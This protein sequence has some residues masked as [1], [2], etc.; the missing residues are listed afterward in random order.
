[1]ADVRKSRTD[2]LIE[3]LRRPGAAYSRF[4]IPLDPQ[5]GLI[6][7]FSVVLVQQLG[8]P[9]PATPV[10][11][12]AGARAAADPLHGAYALGLA[13][14]ASAIGSLP[15]FWA[16]RRYGYRVLRLV[17]RISLSPDAC[18]RRTETLFERYG[19]A[20]LVVAKFVP[21]LARVGPPLA[22]TFRYGAGGF[23]FFYGLGNA[24]WAGAGL[25]AGVVFQ[26]EIDWFIG[27]LALFGGHAVLVVLGLLALY[28]AYRWLVRRRFLASLRTS[29]I[30]VAELKK[31]MERGEMPIV[32]DVRS[33]THRKLD[34]R[35]IP[36]ARAIDLEDLDGPL[37]Q[38]PG[39]RD[40]VVYCA[41]PN[42][43][44]AVRVATLL[45]RH[46]ISQVRSLAGGFDAWF[47]A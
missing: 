16:G 27:A 30:E 3:K 33:S 47:K 6:A 38:I 39:G 10:L 40:V 32:L 9:I 13:I 22:G 1:M 23:L 24:L 35:M 5:A 21:G 7:V 2:E 43:A 15:W 34:P 17:C 14:L 26:A 8:A 46:G 31:R 18:V 45:R 36:G 25:V 42:D 19:A 12:L 20:S 41:C 44:T 29:R 11:M 37:A 28:V 4:R